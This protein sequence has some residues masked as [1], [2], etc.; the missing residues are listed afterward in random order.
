MLWRE[1]FYFDKNCFSRRIHSK[2]SGFQKSAFLFQDWERY[3]YQNFQVFPCGFKIRWRNCKR[4]G[5]FCFLLLERITG[6]EY[7]WLEWD[8]CGCPELTSKGFSGLTHIIEIAMSLVFIAILS[9][10]LFPA[11]KSAKLMSPG[12]Q[13][14]HQIQISSL[15]PKG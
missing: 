11:A 9:L 15:L 2:L 14:N 4:A 12:A 6:R 5:R 13:F 1:T 3:F 8:V 10:E 7:L